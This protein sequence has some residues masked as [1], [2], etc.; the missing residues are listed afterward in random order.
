[1]PK[2]MFDKAKMHGQDRDIKIDMETNM[3][4]LEDTKETEV[5]IE[6]AFALAKHEKLRKEIRASEEHLRK[7]C[8]QY[9]DAA[10]TRGFAPHHLAQACKARG[11]M[12]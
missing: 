11:L 5:L 3:T 1:M 10:G 8:R 6:A 7:L 2:K 9:D 4:V 12:A